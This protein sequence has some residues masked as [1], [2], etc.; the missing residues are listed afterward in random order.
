ML[1]KRSK[2][3]EL[4]VKCSNQIVIPVKSI[5]AKTPNQKNVLRSIS[6]NDLTIVSGVAGSGKTMLSV[7]MAVQFLYKGFVEKIILI[8]SVLE[9]GEKVGFLKGDLDTKIQ[10][11]MQPFYDSLYKLVAPEIIQQWEREQKLVFCPVSFLRGR[12]LENSVIIV[13]EAQNLTLQQLLMIV[14]RLGQGSKMIITGDLAQSDLPPREQGAMQLLIENIGDLENIA[15]CQLDHSDIQRHVLVGKILEKLTNKTL[16]DLSSRKRQT[17]LPPRK[18]EEYYRY[19]FIDEG[20][21]YD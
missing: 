20:N 5:V 21:D 15:I 3:L 10:P 13:D 17:P 14:T 18:L 8:R 11:F 16:N 9:C 19:N 2:D 6:G 1:T 4:Q 12:D 7:G